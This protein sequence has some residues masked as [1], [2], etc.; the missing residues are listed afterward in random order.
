[1]PTAFKVGIIG[2]GFMGQAHA[3]RWIQHQDVELMG[4]CDLD[5]DSAKRIEAPY[6]ADVD[7]LLKAAPDVVDI[8]TPTTTHL[9]LIKKVAA[10]GKAIMVEKP[11]ARTI[12]DCDEV[13]ETVERHG[14]PVMAAHVLRYFPEYEAARRMVNE[15]KI[16]KPATARLGRL[17]PFPNI[18]KKN[19]WYADTAASGG[20]VLDMI[21]HDLDWL[22]WCFGEVTRIFAKGLFERKFSGGTLLDYALVTMRF[23]SGVLAHVTGSWAHTSGFRTTLEVAGDAGMF[24]HDSNTSAPLNIGMRG[25]AGDTAGGVLVPESPVHP[26]EDPYYLE[27][28]AFLD[29]L[30]N[31]TSPP[32]TVR[33]AR[34]AVRISLA[35]LE[36]IQTGKVVTLS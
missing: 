4:I 18:T 2:A 7:A 31:K 19:N 24:E 36:S 15:G 21:I 35:V 17:A 10:A 26:L 16:G 33:D 30:K 32:I 11:L 22:R 28:R 5:R 20:V 9:P 13:V 8:C 34:E 12:S 14:V 27:Q 23:K 1:M 3:N 25:A 6:F 29:S